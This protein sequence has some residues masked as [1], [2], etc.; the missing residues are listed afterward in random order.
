MSCAHL[1]GK[2]GRYIYTHDL[3]K[4]EGAR[5]S[6]KHLD[7][8]LAAIRTPLQLTAWHQFL[9]SHPDQDFA[10]Y[11]LRGIEE[12]FRIGANPEALLKPA[13]RNMQSAQQH[14]D[15]IGEYLQTET[16]KQ[17]ILGP[18][19]PHKSQEVH[20]NR[21]GV[22]PKKHQ[23]GK[24]RLITDLSFPE[25]ASVNDAIDPSLCSLKYVTVD[26]VAKKAIQ[27]GIGS[28]IAK[29]DI[30]SAYRLIPVSPLDRHYLGM[31]WNGQVYVDGMLPFGLRSAPKIFNAVA[32][33]LEWCI[34]KEG[35]EVI[36]HYLDDFATLG[37]PNSEECSRNLHTLQSVCKKL[38][39]P[40][41]A[42]KQAGPSTTIEFLGI[43]I[44]TIRQELRLPDNKLRRLQSLLEEWKHRKSCTRRE[45]ESLIGVLQHACTVV[46][47]GRTFL[48]QVIALLSVAKQPHHH[49]RLNA[50]FQSDLTWWRIFAT[51]WNGSSL[52]VRADGKKAQVTTDASGTWG[53]GG[54][55]G[56]EW[57][58]L[59][60]D[61]KSMQLHITVKELVPILIA[62]M[63]WG[64]KWRGY[65]VTVLC[66]NEAVVTIL[67]SRYC[68]EPTL[69]HMLRVLFFAEAH[70]QFRLVAQHIPGTCNTLADHLSRN[71][72][73]KFHKKFPSANEYASPVPFS[74]LQWLL[75]TQVD[76]TSEHW[77]QLFITF[78]N[79]E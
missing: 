44:D 57:F 34:A 5:R 63:T 24:W 74:V 49:I 3:L 35:V 18:F 25:G 61:D 40:L 78:V 73:N 13:S 72:L 10:G 31:Q 52:V 51:S 60:W 59:A 23:P 75:D 16:Q 64:Q 19:P 37:P 9:R 79:K 53:C 27:L 1:P 38:G 58:Q 70:Y 43:T 54:W 26:Q 20:I 8:Q 36:Y 67:G 33:A 69:M 68:K 11:I 32:D 4:L 22:I 17:N 39:I 2:D 45:L 30:K 76:W 6:S 48:R 42:E 15:I 21:F 12:G 29:I 66:D 41:A 7:S 14:P 28:L 55:S 56:T 71:Q 46:A 47:P 77:T 50:A 65:I 62:V